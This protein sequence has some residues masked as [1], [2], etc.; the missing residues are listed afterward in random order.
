VEEISRRSC[1]IVLWG[2][3]VAGLP[4]SA[5]TFLAALYV[6]IRTGGDCVPADAAGCAT[7][8]VDGP[9]GLTSLSTGVLLELLFEVLV[10]SD[11]PFLVGSGVDVSGSSVMGTSLSSTTSPLAVTNDTE[12][13]GIWIPVLYTNFSMCCLS[14]KNSL[15]FADWAK[16][17]SRPR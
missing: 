1:S 3:G 15:F 12:N 10:R 4:Q 9:A 17:S 7:V 5:N 14:S 8:G 16:S 11:F 2:S 13:S 6:S